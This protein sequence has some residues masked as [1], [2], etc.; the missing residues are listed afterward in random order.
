ML[1]VN[2]LRGLNNGTKGPRARKRE[3][4]LYYPCI[5]LPGFTSYEAATNYLP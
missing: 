5:F 1:V 2:Y 3:Q 4:A